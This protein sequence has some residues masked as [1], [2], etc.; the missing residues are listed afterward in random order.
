[1]P[2]IM[3][4]VQ[5]NAS[6]AQIYC[7]LTDQGPLQGWWT[8]NR[9]VEAKV[10]ALAEFQL[11]RKIVVKMRVKELKE[12]VRVVWQCVAGSPDWIGTEIT[13]DLAAQG[14]E[15]LVRFRHRNWREATDFMGLCSAKWAR[16]LFS[17]KSL[18]ETPD[19]EDLDA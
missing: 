18:I 4:T 9:K 8:K 15:T 14:N 1:M 10:E 3:H 17:L 11:D 2:E 7:A 5:M 12:G 19:P 16:F 6:P 13:F